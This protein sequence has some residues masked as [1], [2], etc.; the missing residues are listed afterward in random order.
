MDPAVIFVF[1]PLAVFFSVVTFFAMLS[2]HL[3]MWFY[4][5]IRAD[6]L[7]VLYTGKLDML[8]FAAFRH[9]WQAK[10][11]GIYSPFCNAVS[12]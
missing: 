7:S 12:H 10:G 8:V 4:G 1:M 3:L 2:F 6:L 5:E 11:Y 9:K